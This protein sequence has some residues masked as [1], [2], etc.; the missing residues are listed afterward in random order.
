MCRLVRYCYQPFNRS[1]L[2]AN[3]ASTDEPGFP[4]MTGAPAQR[5][6]AART[7]PASKRTDDVLP[8]HSFQSLLAELA[9]FA[10]NTM[11]NASTRENIFLVLPRADTA[12]LRSFE[13]LGVSLAVGINNLRPKSAL[14][15]GIEVFCVSSKG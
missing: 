3:P 4:R 6:S 12:Q 5:S 2:R 10:R 1:F 14:S 15:G 11:A 13:P 8:V 7:R 9:T